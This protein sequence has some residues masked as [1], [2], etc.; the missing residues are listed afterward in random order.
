MIEDFHL[1]DDKYSWKPMDRWKVMRT[2]LMDAKNRVVIGSDGKS[3][4]EEMFRKIWI[5]PY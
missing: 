5:K 4:K 2:A 3:N 1:N